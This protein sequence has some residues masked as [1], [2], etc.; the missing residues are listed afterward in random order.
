[1]TL[2]L[3][4]LVFGLFAWWFPIGAWIVGALTLLVWGLCLLV[5]QEMR[6]DGIPPNGPKPPKVLHQ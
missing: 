1:M 5:R 4:L 6:E 3:A 2:T